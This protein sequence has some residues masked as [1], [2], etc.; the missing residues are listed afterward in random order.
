[1]Y[2]YFTVLSAILFLHSTPRRKVAMTTVAGWK[3]NIASVFVRFGPNFSDYCIAKRRSE[4][5]GCKAF[6]MAAARGGLRLGQVLLR[7]TISRP[8]V[9]LGIRNG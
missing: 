6:K 8:Q 5:P 4:I 3:G 2:N 9:L 1:M 7:R